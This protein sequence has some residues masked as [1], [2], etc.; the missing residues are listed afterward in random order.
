MSLIVLAFLGISE[1]ERF[2]SL[3]FHIFKAVLNSRKLFVLFHFPENLSET[4]APCLG[5]SIID[6]SDWRH[7]QCSCN[8]WKTTPTLRLVITFGWEQQHSLWGGLAAVN[9]CLTRL[10]RSLNN[11]LIFEAG[12]FSGHFL[13]NKCFCPICGKFARSANEICPLT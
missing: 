10:Y 12:T 6:E 3:C 5:Y 4:P 2:K 11:V 1:F 13:R 8:P 7:I 9:S